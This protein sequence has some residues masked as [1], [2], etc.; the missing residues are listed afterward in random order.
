M[1]TITVNKKEL[2]QA[3]GKKINDKELENRLSMMGAP[4]DAVLEHEI[5]VDITPNR[6]DWLSEQG[7]ARSLSSFLGVKTGLRDYKV[8]KAN[9]QVVVD[10]SVHAVRPYTVC[11][12]VRGLKLDDEK[13]REIIQ[14][15]EKLHVTFC[16]NRKR[17][18]IGIYPL[19]RI[20]FPI[21]YIAKKPEEIVFVPLESTK[22]MHARQLLVQ[23]PTG[24]AYAH[25]LE[26]QSRFPVFLDAKGNVL[27]VPPIVNS[28][29]TGK[30]TEQTKDIFIECSGFDLHS[31]NLLLNILVTMFADMGGKVFSVDVKYAKKITT[32]DLTPRK[33]KVD[34]EAVNTLLGLELKEVELKRLLER[35]G[36]GYTNKTA[37]IPAYRADIMHLVD[38]VEDIAIAYGYDRLRPEIPQVAT[39]ASEDSFAAFQD[40]LANFLVG[41]G[42]LEAH[43]YHV[44]NVPAQ[45]KMMNYQANVIELA[46]A[47][48][49]EYNALRAWFLPSLIEVLK[50]NKMKDYP[51]KFFGM[52]TVFLPNAKSPSQ[53][54]E[55]IM[56]GIISAHPKADYTE[57]RQ[58]VEY[59]FRVIGLPIV[60]EE[61]EHGSFVSGRAAQVKVDGHTIAILGEI[62][63]QVITNHNLEM[64]V[65]ATEIN[66]T[67]LFAHLKKA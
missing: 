20:T 59:L 52:G 22:E 28:Q 56:L 40:T 19:D 26:G 58:I 1:S 23:H 60:I 16:R 9:Y 12:V 17:A 11:A 53:I 2:L 25:L 55:R 36:F 18:A 21:K 4:V 67:E 61:T 42:L 30:V 64:P 38:L 54:E 45:T 34:L 24:R 48:T 7:L 15:Q 32:P 10:K 33:M 47:L 8:I 49:V 13:I 27:S 65:A 66:L 50:V 63:P 3:A 41:L 46:N 31:L 14:V 39:V 35:M 62:N 37:L 43:T 44:T 5:E 51:Q 6:P 29:L 57:I